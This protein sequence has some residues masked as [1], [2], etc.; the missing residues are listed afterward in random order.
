MNM[1]LTYSL[2]VPKGTMVL[3]PSDIRH[4]VEESTINTPRVSLAFN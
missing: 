4:S 1:N 2:D 3:F